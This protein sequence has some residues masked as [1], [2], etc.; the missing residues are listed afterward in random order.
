MGL[1]LPVRCG[2]CTDL[3]VCL[4]EGSRVINILWACI[5]ALLVACAVA[6]ASVL[7]ANAGFWQYPDVWFRYFEIGICGGLSV[8]GLVGF[9]LAMAEWLRERE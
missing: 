9:F 2:C 5:S 4:F 1:R 8:L 7:G 6:S 3:V